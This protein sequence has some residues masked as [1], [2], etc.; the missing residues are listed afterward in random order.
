MSFQ[1]VRQALA[2]NRWL[3]WQAYLTV[4]LV[5]NGIRLVATYPGPK[6]WWSALAAPLLLVPFLGCMVMALRLGDA[7]KRQR[8]AAA[9][10]AAELRTL[11]APDAGRG[12]CP[13]CAMD[14][15]DELA[16]DDELMDRGPGR[17]KVVAYGSRR[18]HRDCAELVPYVAPPHFKSFEVDGHKTYCAC[19]QCEPWAAEPGAYYRC[20]FCGFYRRAAGMDAAK[21][22]LIAHSKECLKR[23]T[24]KSVKAQFGRLEVDMGRVAAEIEAEIQA[25][26]GRVEARRDEFAR[27]YFR[28]R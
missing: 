12:Q 7:Q 3:R 25:M 9:A 24:V 11:R 14:D 4:L 21:E 28:R 27:E 10:E 15:L 2:K 6:T 17:C 1:Q 16:A 23:P 5:A 18:A 19:K 20:T 8:E 26:N 22:K 13:V